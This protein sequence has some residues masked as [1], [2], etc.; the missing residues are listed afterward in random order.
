MVEERSDSQIRTKSI[1]ILNQC[2]IKEIHLEILK[3]YKHIVNTAFPAY[4]PRVAVCCLMFGEAAVLLLRAWLA[5]VGLPLCN[6]LQP[7]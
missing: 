3:V 7:R 1:S 6:H 2:I 4:L 5:A